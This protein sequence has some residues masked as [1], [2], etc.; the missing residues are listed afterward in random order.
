MQRY[1]Q[2]RVAL[3]TLAGS[4]RP[5]QPISCELGFETAPGSAAEVPDEEPPDY[6][7]EPSVLV[8]SLMG[9]KGLQAS[10]VF[11]L[12]MNNEH[13]PQKNAAPTEAEVCQLLVALTRARESC[14]IVSV[15]NFGGNW[16][17][18][19]IFTE[20]LGPFL[21]EQ[22]IDKKYFDSK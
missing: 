20:W 12:G 17:N 18:D 14:T 13:F 19:S 15:G 2:H 10:H 8:T 5:L 1:E 16:L 21:E 6:S 9:A 3:A 4:F 22:K 11:I 7:H